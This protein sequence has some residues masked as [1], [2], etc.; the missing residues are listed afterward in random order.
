MPR[1]VINPG[2]PEAWEIELQ[3]GTT[4]LGRSAE[5]DVPVEHASVSSTH[6]QI[7]LTDTGA[8]LKDLGSTSGTFVEGQ[9]IEQAALRP[10]QLFWLGEVRMQFDSDAPV[11]AALERTA[12]PADSIPR[13]PR[14]PVASPGSAPVA[15]CKS[16]PR[17]PARYACPQCHYRFCDLCVT[18]RH[19]GGGARIY[20][21]ACGVE[22][23][24]L[25]VRPAPTA[26]REAGL[27]RRL[28]GAFLYPFRGDGLILLG[29][30]T[31][32]YWVLGVARQA[33]M[34]SLLGLIS[35][36][37]LGVFGTGYLIS[38]LKRI[39]TNSALGEDA[40]PDWPD[41]SDVWADIVLPFFQFVG[42]VLACFLPAIAVAMFAAPDNPSGRWGLV[43]AGLF[44]CA[45]FP[46]AFL[47]VS[48]FDS[49]AAVNPLL[50]VPSIAKIPL[51]YLLTIALLGGVLAAQWAGD[52]ALAA[53]LP[54]P[55]LPAIISR[56]IG[57]Y[58][59]TVEMRILGLL[60]LANKA[61][62][63]WFNR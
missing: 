49:V 23:A 51:A 57:L 9:L 50:V 31:F 40:L 35:L 18:T 8:L 26:A 28:G 3:P 38:Y 46:M 55:L 59:L 16:H 45:Y 14:V 11:A 41:A 33:A 43:A 63:G 62:L 25:Q 17:T 30:G 6:C 39:V 54:V 36:M 10:G 19:S 20:C 27:A 47:A 56:F 34:F 13:P 37:I 22:C 42:T 44:G 60:Y 52:K 12:P 15:C 21:R 58:L 2:T 24:S 29:T 5:N 4:S 32:F 48:M 1:L 61:R 53:V 7:T